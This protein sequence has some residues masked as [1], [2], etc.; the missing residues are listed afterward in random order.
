MK[1]LSLH[2][3]ITD[4]VA[5]HGVISV[6]LADAVLEHVAGIVPVGGDERMAWSKLMHQLLVFIQ[7]FEYETLP[8]GICINTFS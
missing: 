8:A 1:R 6:H 3:I 7:G 5:H 2:K 4:I